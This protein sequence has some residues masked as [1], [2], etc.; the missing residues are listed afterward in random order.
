M[1]LDD[2]PDNFAT[3]IDTP[4]RWLTQ[5]TAKKF[6]KADLTQK[7]ALTLRMKQKLAKQTRRGER[8]RFVQKYRP[9]HH[10]VVGR[11]SQAS[12]P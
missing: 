7:E 4:Y 10:A 6:N 2:H 3:P 12:C 5:K 9:Q 8:R 11:S 1:A